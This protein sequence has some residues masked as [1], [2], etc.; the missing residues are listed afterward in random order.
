MS[1]NKIDFNNSEKERKECV[2]VVDENMFKLHT[3]T[4]GHDDKCYIDYHVA[5]S[6]GPGNYTLYNNYH[7]EEQAKKVDEIANKNPYVFLKKGLDVPRN[8]IDDSSNL[9]IGE[10]QKSPKCPQ[11]LFHRPFKTVPYKGRGIPSNDLD[12]HINNVQ[13]NKNKSH[14]Y[15]KTE[16]KLI[17][18]ELTHSR[19][20]CN[21]LSG[22]TI[23]HFFTPL[24]P[25][26]KDN[27]QNPEHL[28]EE[29]AEDG[30]VRGGTPSRLLIRDIDYLQR[31][32]HS[33]TNKV[34]NSEFW[35][36]KV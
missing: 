6:V 21:V 26:L 27:V 12:E 18:G 22:V 16:S 34:M 32:G 7:C 5:Q 15:F 8:N 2:D 28:I 10:T 9:R 14:N 19:R 1:S 36:E 31:C 3:F 24:V 33:Y 13:E 25:H 35:D 29:V 4:K 11:Q 30:W 17:H 20:E 23:P